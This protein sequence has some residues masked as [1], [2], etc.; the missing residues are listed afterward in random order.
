VPANPV[1]TELIRSKIDSLSDEMLHLLYRSAYSTLMRESRDCSYLATTHRGE[2]VTGGHLHYRFALQNLM[3]SHAIADGD[4]YITNHPYQAGVQ[5]TPDLM[6]MLPVYLNGRH[7]A[8]SCTTAHKSDVG[9]AVVGSASMTSTD[10]FQEG[11]LIP[12]LKIGHIEG[13]GF[14]LDENILS[15]ISNN[16]RN[17]DLFIGDMRAQIGV[18]LVGRERICKIA[19]LYGVEALFDSYEAMLDYSDRTLRRSLERWP[20]DSV[21]VE[22]FLDNDGVNLDTPVRY[23]L[24]VTKSGDTIVFDFSGSDDQTDGPVNMQK[25]YMEGAVFGALLAMT[26][27]SA[28]FNDGMRRPVE[29]IVREG[30]VFSPHFPAPVGAASVVNHRL[31]HLIQEALGHFAPEKAVA[32]G[33]GSGGTLALLWSDDLGGKTSRSMQYEV[34]GTGGGAW[35]GHDG[36]DGTGPLG[37]TPVEIL[38]FQFPMRI[39]RFELI[40]DSGGAGEFR[41]GCSYRREY[42]CLAPATL[43][44]RADRGRFPAHGIAGGHPGS[45][46]RFVLDSGTADERAVPIAGNYQFAAGDSFMVEGSGAGGYGDPLRREI[47]AVARDLAIGRVSR[48]SATDD[49]GVVFDAAGEIDPEA[50]AEHR[51]DLAHQAVASNS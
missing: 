18:T 34:L 42:E 46:S 19:E 6:V 48:R 37:I 27:P 36:T 24:T 41:G 25:P 20:D 28:G 16:V 23:E 26:D 35:N 8:F 5:H 51:R 7:I 14:E 29:V 9:G 21:T 4:I 11:L 40:E 49:Y 10:L 33:G 22:G 3:A 43:N 50:T 12:I 31:Q 1:V 44:R 17:P 15:M 39:K 38:E 30:S 45:L 47:A 32:N 13:Q 2:L